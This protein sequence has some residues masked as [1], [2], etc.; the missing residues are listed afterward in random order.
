MFNLLLLSLFWE[1]Q[2]SLRCSHPSP[3]Q[4]SYWR[5]RQPNQPDGSK[6][7]SMFEYIHH[8]STIKQ[9]THLQD[10]IFCQSVAEV[11]CGLSETIGTVIWKRFS[12]FVQFDYF[13][14]CNSYPPINLNIV[15][16]Y[17][18]MRNGL[19]ILLWFLRPLITKHLLPLRSSGPKRGWW[20]ETTRWCGSSFLDLGTELAW[21]VRFVY[22]DSVSSVDQSL[23]VAILY[24]I[25]L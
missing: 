19:F 17:P 8:S 23:S 10:S 14:W 9:N 20:R 2:C 3:T 5:R 6:C 15:V 13:W 11:V 7:V 4:R 16:L 12:F 22:K 21:L 25:T 1:L 18:W 24:Q